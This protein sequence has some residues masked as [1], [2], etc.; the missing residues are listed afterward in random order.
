[1]T[2][3]SFS[4]DEF[5]ESMTLQNVSAN[6]E[7]IKRMKGWSVMEMSK[8]IGISDRHLDSLLK[9]NSNVTVLVLEKIADG[10]GIPVLRLMGTRI[11]VRAHKAGSDFL[12]EIRGDKWAISSEDA[13]PPPVRATRAQTR[14]AA[15][16]AGVVQAP[17]APAGLEGLLKRI[18]DVQDRL[19]QDNSQTNAKV[20]R[21]ANQ[22]ESLVS[23]V[24]GGPGEAAP[25][26]APGAKRGP[27]GPRKTKAEDEGS[28]TSRGKGGRGGAAL[29]VAGATSSVSSAAQSGAG[30]DDDMFDR[31]VP[32]PAKRRG[33][34]PNAESAKR[35]AREAALKSRGSDSVKTSKGT[36]GPGAPK[37]AYNRKK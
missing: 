31:S 14:K 16:D 21:L 28:T 26:S 30:A 6:L 5:A 25:S 8:H 23:A 24:K 34:P 12:E 17:E 4:E 19:A 10:L 20:D 33:R 22:V 37:R 3:Q 32:A 7:T 27:K 18:V 2:R 36:K 29:T 1:M 11:V 15:K 13:P 9:M 35:P